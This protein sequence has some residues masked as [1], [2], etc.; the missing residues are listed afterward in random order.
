MKEKCEKSVFSCECCCNCKYQ[1]KLM[2]HPWNGNNVAY[3]FVK[4][5]IQFGKGSISTQCGWVCTVDINEKND[6]AIFYDFEHGMCE[7][8]EPRTNFETLNNNKS[9]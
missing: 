9:K 2:C 6:S 4:D 1:K 5:K 7:M 3:G 8:H